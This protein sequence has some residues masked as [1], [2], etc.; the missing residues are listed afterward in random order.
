MPDR[1]GTQPV[2][3]DI[4]GD[5]RSELV[6]AF[7]GDSSGLYLLDDA[8]HRFAPISEGRVFEGRLDLAAVLMDR[9]DS[10]A[11][12]YPTLGDPDGDGVDELLTG[13][14]SGGRGVV[15]LLGA[16]AEGFGDAV[17]IRASDSAYAKA[18][19]QAHPSLGDLDGDGRD[20]LV[21][22]FGPSAGTSLLVLDDATSDFSDFPGLPEGEL[23]LGGEPPTGPIRP[24]IR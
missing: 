12:L 14:G 15:L 9:V 18:D 23:D 20:E 19:G 16:L 3:G 21:I 8:T 2:A 11:R 22:G 13:F 7:D 6:L 4:D 5:G 17:W 10:G 1:S 24:C